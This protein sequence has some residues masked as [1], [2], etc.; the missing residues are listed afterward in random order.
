MNI[1]NSQEEYNLALILLNLQEE[2]EDYLKANHRYETWNLMLA[3]KVIN[4]L[5]Q[6]G[7]DL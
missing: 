4:E 5:R 7:F 1:L 6:K 2:Y 3:R